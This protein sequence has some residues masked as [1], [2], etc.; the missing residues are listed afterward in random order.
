MAE[1]A[2]AVKSILIRPAVRVFDPILRCP[3]AYGRRR[4]VS[5]HPERHSTRP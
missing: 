2:G 5:S 1:R 4:T 3:D